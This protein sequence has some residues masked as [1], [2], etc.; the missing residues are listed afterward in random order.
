LR[1]VTPASRDTSGARTERKGLGDGPAITPSAGARNFDGTAASSVTLA[2]SGQTKPRVA[3]RGHS[4]VGAAHP[5][6]CWNYCDGLIAQQAQHLLA[7]GSA[8]ARRTRPEETGKLRA[9]PF[10]SAPLS[11]GEGDTAGAD[12]TTR[13]NGSTTAVEIK[14]CAGFRTHRQKISDDSCPGHS[15]G[16]ERRRAP[17][18]FWGHVEGA[19]LAP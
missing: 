8:R 13:G 16:L 4:A 12:M 7:S 15:D 11:Q 3:S 9:G 6:C 2:A 19:G 18:V 14:R 17:H 10:S 1:F 5:Y